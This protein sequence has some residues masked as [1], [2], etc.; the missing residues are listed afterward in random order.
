MNERITLVSIF[1][2]D[3]LSKIQYYIKYINRNLCKVP[4]GKNVNNREEADTLPYHFTLLAWDISNKENVINKLSKLSFSKLRIL[5]N[6]VKIRKGK[7]N[8]YV[9]Y[10][11]I[12][13]NENLKLLQKNIYKNLPCE[14]YNP[15]NFNFHITIHID[16]DYSKIIL[17]KEKIL[18]S[19]IP[20]EIE[21]DTF[22]LYEIYPAKL[23]KIFKEEK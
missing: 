4:F 3:N 8:S 14:K 17:M 15:N 21:V 9:L 2:N 11:N 13:D 20:F 18:E 22:G 5:I 1:N 7:E 10:F 6:D 23:L 19:F 12:E 16:K